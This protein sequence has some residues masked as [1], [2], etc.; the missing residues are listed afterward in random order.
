MHSAVGRRPCQNASQRPWVIASRERRVLFRRG[1]SSRGADR[2]SPRSA[3][4]SGHWG[5]SGLGMPMKFSRELRSSNGVR[6]LGARDQYL[7]TQ[8]VRRRIRSARANVTPVKEG[9][10][11]VI[12]RAL[13]CFLNGSRLDNAAGASRSRARHASNPHFAGSDG[14][15]NRSLETPVLPEETGRAE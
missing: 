13:P 11:A 4:L 9:R 14:P 15:A 10:C 7:I 6:P 5:R 3:A 8:S 2:C 1:L 12:S